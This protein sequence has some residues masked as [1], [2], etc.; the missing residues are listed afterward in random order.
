MT[1]MIT[2]GAG[3]GTLISYLLVANLNSMPSLTWLFAN[4]SNVKRHLDASVCTSHVL[5]S[6]MACATNKPKSK[7]DLVHISGS[8]F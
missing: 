8:W 3:V 7:N 6:N 1:A 4:S 5:K 2:Y